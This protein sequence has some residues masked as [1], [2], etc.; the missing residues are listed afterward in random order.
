ML[1]RRQFLAF[2]GSVGGVVILQQLSAC[3]RGD[4]GLL[5]PSL[6]KSSAQ[7]VITTGSVAD[8]LQRRHLEPIYH[9][10]TNWP[11]FGGQNLLLL[12]D[13]ADFGSGYYHYY[14]NGRLMLTPINEMMFDDRRDQLL[15][16]RNGQAVW[17]YQ[18][19]GRMIQLPMQV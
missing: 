4:S 5:G 12:V 19:S 15:I 7:G 2:L 13:L 16:K 9:L 8:F 14:L 10:Q 3:S 18:P 11:S 17:R 6:G 1:N